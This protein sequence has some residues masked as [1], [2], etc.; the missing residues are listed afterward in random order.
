[1]CLTK[2]FKIKSIDGAAAVLDDG[3]RVDLGM[4]KGAKTGDWVL[5]NANLAVTK[6]SAQE[7]K[8][9]KNYFKK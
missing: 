4:L 1:M 5:A 9:I 7:A 2:P 6:I 3:R 8:E